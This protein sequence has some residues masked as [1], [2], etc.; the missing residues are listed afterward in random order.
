MDVTGLGGC[1]R[2]RSCCRKATRERLLLMGELMAAG[3]RGAGDHAGTEEG[4]AGTVAPAGF[5]SVAVLGKRQG[6]PADA[7]E[8]AERDRKDLGEDALR[9]AALQPQGAGDCPARPQRLEEGSRVGASR[10]TEGRDVGLQVRLPDPES[11]SGDVR[12]GSGDASGSAVFPGP[13]HDPCPGTKYLWRQ[14]GPGWPMSTPSGAEW[15]LACLA[16]R[17][18]GP[19]G[20]RARRGWKQDGVSE[21]SEGARASGDRCAALRAERAD[22]TPEITPEALSREV[23]GC[24]PAASPPSPAGGLVVAAP[25]LH[26]RAAGLAGGR[27]G[28]RVRAREGCRRLSGPRA[29]APLGRGFMPP[30]TASF[31]RESGRPSIY[32]GDFI[33]GSG[34]RRASRVCRS[35]TCCFTLV[36]MKIS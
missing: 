17:D 24:A 13:L 22:S 1:P 29:D 36:A 33:F 18:A 20:G 35:S 3:R 23:T 12:E 34:A 16:R 9:C 11:R 28:L 14:A 31:R 21:V 5:G 30:W 19:G 25:R 27:R 26:N 8:G 10:K 32:R 7:M 15:A 6:E 4:E 2:L